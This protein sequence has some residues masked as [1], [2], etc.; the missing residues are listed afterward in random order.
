MKAVLQISLIFSLCA[1]YSCNNV[2][3]APLDKNPSLGVRAGF[4]G[5]WK[6]CR[7]TASKDYILV[8][9]RTDLLAELKGLIKADSLKKDWNG[10]ATYRKALD[11]AKAQY[12]R[13]GAH[14]YFLTEMKKGEGTGYQ[15]APAFLSLVNRQLFFNVI[16]S[17][18]RDD[19]GRRRP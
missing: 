4:L 18:N 12:K 5:I 10:V 1:L 16:D 2:A 15:Q 3:R 19:A 14:Y 8:Q 7:D 9:Q 6:E 11:E 13:E 17:S